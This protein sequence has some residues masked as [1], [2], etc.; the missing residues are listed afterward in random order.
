MIDVKNVHNVWGLGL[1]W[2]GEIHFLPGTL[3][4]LPRGIFSPAQFSPRPERIKNLDSC[5]FSQLIT[6]WINVPT[7]KDYLLFI[8]II[9][10]KIW[11]VDR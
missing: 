7:V 8:R 9:D 4:F 6:F 11:V 2:A 5:G 3:F 10:Y 1:N